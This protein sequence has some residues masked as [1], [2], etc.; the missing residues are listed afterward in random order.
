ML[1]YIGMQS[2]TEGYSDTVKFSL[3]AVIVLVKSNGE[4]EKRILIREIGLL[5][6]PGESCLRQPINHSIHHS[7]LSSANPQLL[8]S[9]EVRSSL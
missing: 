3:F 7:F 5:G 8:S 2:D 1:C 6:L 9:V 4:N